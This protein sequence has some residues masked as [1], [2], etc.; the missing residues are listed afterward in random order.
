MAVPMKDA[1]TIRL[2]AKAM[3]L[4]AKLKEILA[5]RESM[6]AANPFRDLSEC[7]SI[8]ARVRPVRRWRHT[9]HRAANEAQELQDFTRL[10]RIQG[11]SVFFPHEWLNATTKP[12]ERITITVQW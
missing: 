12:G 8:A 10:C 1:R 6:D 5:K 11:E 9:Y 2:E 7:N 4:Q 3:A